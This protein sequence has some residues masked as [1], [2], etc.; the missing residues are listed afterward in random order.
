MEE[1]DCPLCQSLLFE[2]ITTSCG[3]SF[4]KGCILR[5]QD[6]SNRC[7]ICRAIIHVSPDHMVNLLLIKTMKTLWGRSYENRTTEA[8]APISEFQLP[9][10]IMKMVLFPGQKIPLNIFEA[11]YKLMIRRIL[12]RGGKFGIVSLVGNKLAKIGTLATIEEHV[13]LP[14]GNSLVSVSGT[15]LFKIT[16]SFD[17]DGYKVGIVE[18]L[19][20]QSILYQSQSDDRKISISLVFKETVSIFEDKMPGILPTVEKK[21]GKMPEG[22]VE[23]SYWLGSLL[24]VSSEQKQ[25]LLECSSVEELLM[26]EVKIL[27]GV[28][29][30]SQTAEVPL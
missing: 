1:Y 12:D 3:H 22:P 27:V 6:H 21:F 5:S 26:Q 10:L 4:C 7:P 2:P 24:P 15:K 25:A 20:D 16:S 8:S 28:A 18:F 23:F 19:A 9:L 29:S 17:Q 13:F 14:N 30:P 11:R